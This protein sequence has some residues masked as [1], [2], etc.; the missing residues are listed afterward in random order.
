MKIIVSSKEY[1]V[2]VICMTII[3]ISGSFCYYLIAYELKYIRGNM[4][5]NGLIS[6]FSELAGNIVSW[7]LFEKIGVKKAFVTAYLIS[8]AGMMSLILTSTDS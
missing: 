3:W 4:Y 1:L 5:I 6:S 8:L 2:N 7:I